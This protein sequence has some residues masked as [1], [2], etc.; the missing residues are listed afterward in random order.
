MNRGATVH[1]CSNPD[2]LAA[3]AVTV[4]SDAI[5]AAVADRGVV[6][7]MFAS[8]NSQLEFLDRLVAPGL[9]AWEHLVGFHMDEYVGIGPDHP[10]SFARYMQDRIIA[11]AT[12]L[13]FHLID[14]RPDPAAECD[15]YAALLAD[16][17]LDLC[18]MGIGE[19]G[20]LAF[21][22]PPVADFSDPRS[23]KV[24]ELDAACRAQQVGEGHF[25]TVDAVPPRAITVTIPALLAARSVIVV[26][27]EARKA[28]PVAAALDGPVTTACPASILQL[29]P[30]AQVFLDPASAADLR[31][32]SG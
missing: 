4:A 19:N 20:H 27:P 18:V 23:V 25:A 13:A 29:A 26:A 1:I 3:L 24:V 15:R 31:T 21:N 9:V 2:D 32:S 8:G 22:D 30:N 16:H 14:G 5:A 7:V 6:H 10:A 28:R 11:R 12:P 17:P